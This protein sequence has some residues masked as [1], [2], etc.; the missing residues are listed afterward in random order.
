MRPI[1]S[2]ID[3]AGYLLMLSGAM[4]IVTFAAN[5]FTYGQQGLAPV[6]LLFIVLGYSLQRTE[7]RWLGYVAFLGVGIGVSFAIREF[8][9]STTSPAWWYLLIIIVDIAAVATLFVF[10]WRSPKTADV[11]S[12][13]EI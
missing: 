8:Y 6:G 10:L 1:N 13:T 5:G 4:H 3:L 7:W 2:L 11:P 9:I 12:R